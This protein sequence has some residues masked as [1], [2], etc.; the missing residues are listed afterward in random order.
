MCLCLCIFF[1][2]VCIT[3]VCVSVFVVCMMNTCQHALARMCMCCVSANAVHVL[4]EF[5]LVYMCVGMRDGY[6]GCLRTYDGCLC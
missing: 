2:V 1:R 5:V 4:C 6:D 3:C